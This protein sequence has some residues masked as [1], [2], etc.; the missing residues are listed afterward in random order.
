MYW[1]ACAFI[2]YYCIFGFSFFHCLFPSRLIIKRG[3]GCYLAFL[4]NIVPSGVVSWYVK[5]LSKSSS[6]LFLSV[7]PSVIHSPLVPASRCRYLCVVLRCLC[8]TICLTISVFWHRFSC[9]VMYACLMS[10]SLI[11]CICGSL[12]FFASLVLNRMKCSL[13]VCE[14]PVNSMSSGLRLFL[15]MCVWSRAVSS[16]VIFIGG[17]A[18]HPLVLRAVIVCW[19]RCMSLARSPFSPT[20]SMGLSPVCWLTCIFMDRWYLAEATNWS[21]RASDGGWMLF[22]SIVYLG[23]SCHVILKWLQ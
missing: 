5:S 4:N 3:C 9:L 17:R 10:Y 20:I 21:I 16:G 22:S 15:V 7:V 14:L 19:S 2:G 12:S 8:P 1:I 18:L 13:Y 23:L 11:A 6:A